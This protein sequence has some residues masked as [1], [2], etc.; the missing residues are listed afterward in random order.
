[1]RKLRKVLSV[2]L[3]VVMMLGM[4]SVPAGAED[5]KYER[6]KTPWFF[7]G[8]DE[9]Q[10]YTLQNTQLLL[11]VNPWVW[12]DEN[13]GS[14]SIECDT[15][16]TALQSAESSI[17]VQSAPD[18]QAAMDVPQTREIQITRPTVAGL[19][20]DKPAPEKSTARFSRS[21]NT[22][23]EGA[24]LT[25]HGAANYDEDGNLVRERDV[26]MVCLYEG[27]YCTV[28]GSTSD[29]QAIQLTKEQAA[30]IG[31]EFDSKYTVMDAIF[32]HDY[33][34]ADGDGKIA[35]MCYDLENEYADG[36]DPDVITN[37]WFDMK[38][39]IS[40]HDEKN[41]AIGNVTFE[42]D[43]YDPLTYN[44]IDCIRIDTFPTMGGRE[45][46]MRDV[47]ACYSTL[48]H[49]YQHMLNFSS[50]L[51][52]LENRKTD[53][54]YYMY[55]FLNE[56][57]S[58]AAEFLAYNYD[59]VK[60]RVTRFNNSY[61][62][63][64]SL[65]TWRSDLDNYASSF[66]FGQY[67]RTRWAQ[68]GAASQEDGR[69]LFKRIYDGC[70]D[71][72]DLDDN[73]IYDD[74]NNQVRYD[75]DALS[76][77]A[78]YLGTDSVDLLRDFWTAVCLNESTGIYGFN[79][80]TWANDIKMRTTWLWFID[81]KARDGSIFNSGAKLYEL[82]PD[83]TYTVTAT[84][85]VRLVAIGGLLGAATA[86]GFA[87]E[88]SPDGAL[89]IYDSYDVETSSTT[90]T[91]APWNSLPEGTRIDYVS[92]PAVASIADGVFTRYAIDGVHFGGSKPEW[93]HVALGNNT[94]LAN[95]SR[96][97]FGEG[98]VNSF[99]RYQKDGDSWASIRVSTDSTT[100][101]FVLAL[102]DENERFLRYE[103]M[104]P[105]TRDQYLYNG[106]YGGWPDMIVNGA[107]KVSVIAVDTSENHNAPRGAASVFRFS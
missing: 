52:H 62:P 67:I 28:W 42:K 73:S 12:M 93:D 65:T 18:G 71:P 103:Y 80:E 69:D 20:D 79:G 68:S 24:K 105:G 33:I 55:T 78:N 70:C 30:A 10:T 96:L 81:D 3:A 14:F 63:G 15:S 91:D 39:M 75:G 41:G 6:V 104:E 90:L 11:A 25:L 107:N 37:G 59:S 53:D 4:L 17:A 74:E 50:S 72:T 95:A 92:L 23:R 21:G 29:A 66:L 16:S 64:S 32:G 27:T 2:V 54:L 76:I 5:A 100:T 97:S 89:Y 9:G 40:Y 49:E 38:D 57:F 86:D 51:R 46:P 47:T 106:E 45:N 60:D 77:V 99:S 34:D 101:A 8:L 94:R 1:M 43:E 58:M 13:V 44:G 98:F 26:E 22:S 7:N 48:I 61:D 36:K 82:D 35:I 56:A 84:S 83:K 87:W 85:N 31:A 102:Y 88:L 19:V